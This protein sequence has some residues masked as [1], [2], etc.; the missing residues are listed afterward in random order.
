M[1]LLLKNEE[2]SGT[3]LGEVSNVTNEEIKAAEADL[4]NNSG[5]KGENV[6]GTMTELE[7][8]IFALIVKKS[9]EFKLKDPFGHVSEISGPGR[10]LWSHI[11]FGPG[12]D[13]GS[14][15]RRTFRYKKRHR[16]S[17][18]LVVVSHPGQ[19]ANT[20]PNRF[21]SPQGLSNYHTHR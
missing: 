11:W 1:D 13:W 6:V 14:R 9:A 5:R 12:R 15:F 3:I 21:W 17:E 19:I 2:I 18:I 4:M 8:K 10:Y 20:Q 16:I 7:K